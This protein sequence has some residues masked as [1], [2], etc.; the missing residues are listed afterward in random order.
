MASWSLLGRCSKAKTLPSYTG[1]R[2]LFSTMCI[3]HMF[4][5]KTTLTCSSRD[6]RNPIAPLRR[7]VETHS[8]DVTAVHF[9]H[10]GSTEVLLSASTD[11]LLAIS[12]PNESDEDEAGIQMQNWGC[13]VS[14]AG[15]I[16]G[17]SSGPRVWA[18]SDMETLSIWNE[19]VGCFCMPLIKLHIKRCSM[20]EA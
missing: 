20:N 4:N 19:E 10:S 16:N 12:N 18:S 13:S 2:L 9:S 11:G 1:S 17:P 3:P 7:H 5:S 14:R 8:D 6:P 15:W